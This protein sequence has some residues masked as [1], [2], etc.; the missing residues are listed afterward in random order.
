MQHPF[1]ILT[2]YFPL[3]Q[4]FESQFLPSSRY[5]V[6][7]IRYNRVLVDPSLKNS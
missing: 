4:K 6:I 7:P 5:F 2:K 1:Q 3:V